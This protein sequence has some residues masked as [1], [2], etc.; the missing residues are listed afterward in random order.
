VFDSGVG[1]LSVLRA[2]RGELPH[3]P[4]IYVAD[5]GFAPYGDRDANF[6]AQR[7][8]AIVR[9][10]VGEGVRA[11]VVACN[12]ATGV[13]VDALRQRF[14]LPIVAIEPAVKPAVATTRSG[15]IGVLATST[16]LTTARFADLVDRH[17]TSV[18]V[19]VQPCP[20]LSRRVELGDLTGAVTRALVEH[21]VRPL[22]EEGADTVVVGCTHY[23]FLIP[24][25]QDVAGAAVVVIDPAAAVA[26][27]LRR[28]LALT[29]LPLSPDGAANEAF[30]SSGPLDRATR[31]LGQ[32]WSA[33]AVA[34]ALP[35]EF[36]TA[37]VAVAGRS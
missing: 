21:Y 37:P 33:A 4:L 13:A 30:W 3:E 2:I 6:I 12:T 18:R 5:S 31:V 20:G 11:V 32:L 10:L 28:R 8:N 17:G 35:A 7:A 16:M 9:F 26:R 25:I 19:V 34:R 14:A 23:A 27:E 24:L 15:V 36:C 22:I 29:G 1:G